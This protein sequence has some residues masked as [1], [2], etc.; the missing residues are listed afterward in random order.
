MFA[1]DMLLMGGMSSTM[2][3]GT[4][5]DFWEDGSKTFSKMVALSCDDRWV[6]FAAFMDL[7][8]ESFASA[9]AN[10]S[11]HFTCPMKNTHFFNLVGDHD[12]LVC[13]STSIVEWNS[14]IPHQFRSFEQVIFPGGHFIFAQPGFQDVKE[15]LA[16]WFAYYPGPEY[17]YTSA[18]RVNE[19]NPDSSLASDPGEVDAAR[20]GERQ[21]ETTQEPKEVHALWDTVS[22]QARS[23]QKQWT[24]VAAL[25]T[26]SEAPDAQYQA[27]IRTIEDAF[28]TTEAKSPEEFRRFTEELWRKSFE[29]LKET[30]ENQIRSR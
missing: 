27:G 21:V 24:D 9:E 23:F 16:K 29:V 4:W 19:G 22:E 17:L 15:R 18:R 8:E 20:L 14:P 6:P 11:L 3:E 12:S 10:P 25:M 30:I 26:N 13:P 7:M 2:L 28:R 1:L 5:Q